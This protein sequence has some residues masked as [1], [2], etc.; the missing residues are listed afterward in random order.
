MQYESA[1][2]SGKNVMAN[3]NVFVHTHADARAMTLAPRTFVPARLKEL[4]EDNKVH[5]V[6]TKF[7]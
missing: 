3:V 1:I 5:R 4:S 6:T 2:T 7:K